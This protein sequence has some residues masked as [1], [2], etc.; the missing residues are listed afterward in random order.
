MIQY[1]AKIKKDN[2][3]YNVEFPD[4]PGCFTYGNDLE[5]ALSN[6][7][8]ALTGYLE[9]IDL[10]KIKIPNPSTLRGK[11]SIILHRTRR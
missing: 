3:S 6:A 8:E 7:K 1:P 4:L 9:S 10:R 11:T 5:S 2:D